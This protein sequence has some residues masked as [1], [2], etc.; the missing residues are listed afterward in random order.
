[1][2]FGSIL[3]QAGVLIPAALAVVKT[4][5]QLPNVI[6]PVS[7]DQ[8]KRQMTLAAA[9]VVLASAYVAYEQGNLAQVDLTETVAA[10]SMALGVLYG[11]LGNVGEAVN[12][13][14]KR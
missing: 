8:P 3:S 14:I 2:D 5:E 7:P 4:A 6:A 9:V 10:A 12:K 13:L 1:M 11:L